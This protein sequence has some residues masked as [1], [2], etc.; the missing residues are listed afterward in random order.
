[1]S[2]WPRAL[3][4]SL[5]ATA[6]LSAAPSP[7]EVWA[8]SSTTLPLTGFGG[9]AVDDAR[10]HVFVSGGPGT[11][12]IAVLDFDGTLVPIEADPATPRLDSGTAAT[13]RSLQG[14][15]SLVTTILSG[16]ALKDPCS[17]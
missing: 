10:G 14:R 5:V 16:R 7:R 2:R 4:A 9:I 3:A 6:F 11:N 1:M 13:L 15:E 12:S 17:D 8:D